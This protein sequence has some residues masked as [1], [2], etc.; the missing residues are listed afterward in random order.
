VP[1]PL[2]AGP[3]ARRSW[4][5][6]GAAVVLL[7]LVFL[8]LWWKSEKHPPQSRPDEKYSPPRWPENPLRLGGQGEAVTVSQNPARL[9]LAW[10]VSGKDS[11]VGLWDANLGAVRGRWTLHGR[12]SFLALSP[13][14]SL[15]AFCSE[16]TSAVQVIHTTDGDSQTSFKSDGCIRALAFGPDNRTLALGL[17]PPRVVLHDA[18]TGRALPAEPE[19]PPPGKDRNIS[20]K[21][22][23]C[24]PNG[25]WLALSLSDGRTYLWETE[26]GKLRH[27]LP[28]VEGQV[29]GLAFSP[30]SKRLAGAVALRMPSV[31]LWNP[32]TGELVREVPWDKKH[33]EVFSV[34]FSR[35]GRLLASGSF[36]RI[37]LWDMYR[38]RALGEPFE[39]E[40]ETGIIRG[41]SFSHEGTNLFSAGYAGVLRRWDVPPLP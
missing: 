19:R 41:L 25:R 35:D 14:A 15:L 7:G 6:L 34:A 38:D 16:C 9:L 12:A 13:D 10:V 33:K 30:D 28:R 4:L 18:I 27:A 3:G 22:V 29:Y 40:H 36:G 5:A 11:E 24:S 8:I 37:L 2:S 17:D 23:A 31:C 21:A 39:T 26:K 32:E 20:V 1:S